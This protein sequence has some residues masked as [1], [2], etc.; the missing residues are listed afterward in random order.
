MTQTPPP[1]PEKP[2]PNKVHR[3]FAAGCFNSTWDLI[4]KPNRTPADVEEMIHRCHASRWHWGQVQGHTPQNLGVGAWQLARVYALAGRLDEARR[5]ADLNLAIC[6]E[7]GLTP[8]E[9]AFAYEA[10]ARIEGMAGNATRRDE[11]LASARAETAK[12]AQ[13]D[14]R[15]W[16]EANLDPIARGE[17][18]WPLNTEPANTALK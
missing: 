9:F 10:L 8:V 17:Y 15:K 6:R 3:A 16:I 13:A 5:Y 11:L 7:H 2:D 14:D 12:V 4:E 18:G 1:S